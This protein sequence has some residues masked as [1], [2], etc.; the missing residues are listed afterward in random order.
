VD[1]QATLL[2]GHHAVR[3]AEALLRT[4]PTGGLVPCVASLAALADDVVGRFERVAE[5]LLR[6][7]RTAVTTKLSA[8]PAIEWPTNLGQA[9]YHLADLRVWLYGL[10]EDLDRITPSIPDADGQKRAELRSASA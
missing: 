8:P 10:R 1:W 2:A 9:L 5:G 7:D 3:G 6:H 4:C